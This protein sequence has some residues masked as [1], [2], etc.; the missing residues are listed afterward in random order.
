MSAVGSVCGPLAGGVLLRHFWWGSV[1]LVNL[2]VVALV[3]LAGYLFVP[4]SW[5]P[6]ARRLDPVG[7]A[8]SILTLV[9][10]LWAIIEAPVRG[11]VSAG[12]LDAFAAAV[13]LPVVFVGWEARVFPAMTPGQA[14]PVPRT[15]APSP[16]DANRRDRYAGWSGETR[17]DTARTVPFSAPS[18]NGTA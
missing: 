7:A 17:C 16:P 11:W 15:P 14:V 13:V 5:D 9:A 12:V 18:D 3:L 1:F 4:D 10:L 2:P 8:L 6:A